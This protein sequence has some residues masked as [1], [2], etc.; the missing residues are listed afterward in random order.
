MSDKLKDEIWAHYRQHQM[1]FLGTYGENRPHVRPVT[2]I[3]QDDKFW[4]AT[5]STDAKIKQIDENEHIEFCMMLKG[6]GKLGYIRGA[7]KAIKIIEPEV[8]KRITDANEFIKEFWPD[9]QDPRFT[10][11]GIELTEIKYLKVGAIL[12]EK[13]IL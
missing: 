10:L 4:V 9:P 8:R 11:L 5:G 7:G 2:L 12:E 6:E 3:Y 13:L 1:A